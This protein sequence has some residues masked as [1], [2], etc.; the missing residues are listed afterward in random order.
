MNHVTT[1]IVGAGQA[2][3][4]ISHALSEHGIDH[5]ILEQ[6][7]VGHAWKTQRWDSLTTLTPNWANGLPGLPNVG[8]DPHGFMPVADLVEY[9]NVSAHRIAAPIRT[10]TEVL[11]VQP[12]SDGYLLKTST[13]PISCRTLVVATGA[14][15][16]AHVPALA[17]HVPSAVVQTDPA[18]YKRPGDLPEGETLV[19]GA[20][21]SGVQIARELALSGRNVTIAVGNH[22]RLPRRYRGHDIEAWLEILGIMDER[23]DEIDDL[24]RARRLPSP[25]LH[26]GSDPVDLN[27]LQA[28]GV[29]IVGRMVDVRNDKALFSGGLTGLVAGADLKMTRLLDQIDRWVQSERVEGLLP[30]ADRPLPTGLPP[31]PPLERPLGKSGIKSVVWA[32]GFRADLGWLGL[33]VFDAR[34]R[35]KHQNG[36]IAM[37]G[38]YAIGLPILM[39]RRSHQISGVQGDAKELATHLRSFLDGH[40]VAAA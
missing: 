37:P 11:A 19:V 27:A 25:Q 38:I 2:G 24:V 28:L 36:I 22:M 6:G 3:L 33:P 18:R 10:Q 29:T 13:G 31:S 15:A 4:A 35:L 5:L 34:G 40:A 7:T 1:A 16:K 21:A 30:D 14:C 8:D 32:T 26:G 20:S 17:S 23:A 9:L 39:R 12:Q